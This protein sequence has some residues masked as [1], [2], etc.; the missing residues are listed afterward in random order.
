MTKRSKV[1][2]A[3]VIALGIL[4]LGFFTRQN[5]KR[6]VSYYE[7]GQLKHQVI[8][9]NGKYDGLWIDYFENG[10]VHAKTEYIAGK[11]N[12]KNII[13]FENGNL[14]QENEFKEDK[15]QVSKDYTAGG[16]LEE[17]RIYDSLERVVDYS[18]YKE[19]GSRDFRR[20]KKDPIF[21][22]V[23]DTLVLGETYPTLIRLGNR[24]YDNIEV[25]IGD[26]EDPLIAKQNPPLPKKDS[27]TSLIDI[28]ADSLGEREISGIIIE[29]SATS[30][31]L[32]VIPFTHRF[33]VTPSQKNY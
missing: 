29:R 16:S 6:E 31:S 25:I 7:N 22:P 11:K 4:A 30:D 23:G 1:F 32:D 26:I 12:G 3:G 19:N 5:I 33:Y 24:Q 9:K 17:I 15:L 14:R 13:Y 20:E 8:L 18:C 21:I 27:L 28:K 2:S 10:T